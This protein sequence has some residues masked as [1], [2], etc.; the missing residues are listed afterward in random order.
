MSDWMD[1][2]DGVEWSGYPLDCYDYQSTCGANKLQ[3]IVLI[4]MM[5]MKQVICI[6]SF[7]ERPSKKELLSL[8][9]LLFATTSTY[10]IFM[11][12][13]ITGRPVGNSSKKFAA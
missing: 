11:V 2:V 12:G 1:G 8:S 4:M 3:L 6:D 10:L 13:S 7:V 5:I 9:F